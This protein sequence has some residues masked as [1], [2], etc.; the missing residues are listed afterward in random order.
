M[1]CL[2]NAGTPQNSLWSLLFILRSTNA[3]E[4]DK[5]STN[6]KAGR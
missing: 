3:I 2:C 5:D 1:N 4:E 6:N